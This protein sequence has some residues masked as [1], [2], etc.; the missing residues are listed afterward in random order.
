MQFS[1]MDFFSKC[2]QILHKKI[3]FSIMNFFSKCDQIRSFVLRIWSHLLKKSIMENFIFC[4]AK[5]V[6]TNNTDTR[7]QI[8]PDSLLKIYKFDYWTVIFLFSGDAIYEREFKLLCR[9]FLDCAGLCFGKNNKN[10]GESSLFILIS[11]WWLTF[12]FPVWLK[13]LY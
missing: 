4:A 13:F 7:K 10:C 9:L 5:L 8:F 6:I 11:C 3:K 2:D 12:G 1:I